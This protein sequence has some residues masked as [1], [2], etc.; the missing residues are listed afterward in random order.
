[1]NL[2]RLFYSISIHGHIHEDAQW[3]DALTRDQS[4]RVILV[5]LPLS[6]PAFAIDEKATAWPPLRPGISP[7]APFQSYIFLFKSSAVPKGR[8]CLFDTASADG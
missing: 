3:T 2:P 8:T 1:M 7:M 4:A 5:L 6:S